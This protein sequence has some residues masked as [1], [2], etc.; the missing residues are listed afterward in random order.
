MVWC[1]AAVYGIAYEEYGMSINEAVSILERMMKCVNTKDRCTE[2][3]CSECGFCI[4]PE[5]MREPLESAI[6]SLKAWDAFIRKVG[7]ENIEKLIKE[8]E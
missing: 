6:L 4:T 8:A 5:V 7:E 1:N 2:M 3:E